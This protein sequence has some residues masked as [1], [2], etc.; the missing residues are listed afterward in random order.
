MWLAAIL[1]ILGLLRLAW[2]RGVSLELRILL[3]A[4]V[5]YHSL[6]IALP[7]HVTTGIGWYLCSVIAAEAALVELGLYEL[8]GRRRVPGLCWLFVALDCM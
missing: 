1:A 7:Q 4:P 5:A 6:V 2:R 3:S 8:V